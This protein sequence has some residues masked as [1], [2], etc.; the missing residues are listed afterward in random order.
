M[1]FYGA[2]QRSEETGHAKVELR[3]KKKEQ[4]NCAMSWKSHDFSWRDE[5]YR[6]RGEGIP[7]GM[8]S[9]EKVA[10]RKDWT[11]TEWRGFLKMENTGQ[12]AVQDRRS[13]GVEG[14]V[15]AWGPRPVVGL[16]WATCAS[17]D[18]SSPLHGGQWNIG[19]PC[20]PVS[21]VL[22]QVGVCRPIPLGCSMLFH[23]FRLGSTL[24]TPEVAILKVRCVQS[25]GFSSSPTAY[26]PD[27]GKLEGVG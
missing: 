2:F 9:W 19:F 23:L 22:D 18:V 5:M 8:A 17:G 7:G 10:L 14:H 4:T 27:D 26:I 24:F 15:M 12:E 16:I 1:C 13:V 20:R 6:W 25:L 21:S 11:T 3:K